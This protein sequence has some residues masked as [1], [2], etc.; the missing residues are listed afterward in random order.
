MSPLF[1]TAIKNRLMLMKLLLQSEEL[2][3]SVPSVSHGDSEVSVCL[4]DTWNLPEELPEPP[5]PPGTLSL[6]VVLLLLL[7]RLLL[8]PHLA[9][10]CC[11]GRGMGGRGKQHGRLGGC[12][13]GF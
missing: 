13:L 2:L 10:L 7:P 9:Q 5:S 8:L 6:Q 1:V 4:T 11:S 12:S 3:I